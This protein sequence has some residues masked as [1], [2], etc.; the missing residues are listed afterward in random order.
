MKYQIC[1]KNERKEFEEED[2]NA[3]RVKVFGE[4]REKK[5]WIIEEWRLISYNV[6]NSK[7]FKTRKKN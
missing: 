5:D 7:V 1:K 4:S 6:K 3:I 2:L